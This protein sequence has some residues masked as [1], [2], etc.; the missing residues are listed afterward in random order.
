VLTSP[1]FANLMACSVDTIEKCRECEH[2]SLCGGA[3]RAWG[4]QTVLDV[5][6]AP[7]QCDHLKQRAQKLTQAAREYL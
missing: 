5:N 6:A 3:C 2:R 1:G 4:N 7:P